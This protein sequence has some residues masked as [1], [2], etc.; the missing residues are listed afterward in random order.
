MLEKHLE[1]I[2]G[3]MTNLTI[4]QVPFLISSTLVYEAQTSSSEALPKLLLFILG[5]HFLSV[6][7]M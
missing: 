6:N 7:T 1:E 5:T 2:R 3:I 4:I